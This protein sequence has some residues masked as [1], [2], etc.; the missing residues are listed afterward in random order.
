MQSL[1]PGDIVL[2]PFPFE[3]GSGKKIRPCL[4][5]AVKA[6]RFLAAKV[7]TTELPQ[8]WGVYLPQGSEKCL[9]G[10]IRKESWIKLRGVMWLYR[11]DIIHKIAILECD[12]FDSI[13]YRI[14]EAVE[15]H[16]K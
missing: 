14:R 10:E 15:S 5:L 12:F 7:T 16:R 9:Q 11:E 4:V 2:A 8:V 6:D 1:A 3:E 13:L